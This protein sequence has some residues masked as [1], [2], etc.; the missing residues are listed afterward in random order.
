MRASPLPRRL[1]RLRHLLRRNRR[2][3]SRRNIVAHYDLGDDFYRLRLDARMQCSSALWADDTPTSPE[4]AGKARLPRCFD[5]LASDLNPGGRPW[6][7]GRVASRSIAKVAL[8]AT[9][10]SLTA[11][12]GNWRS[13][14]FRR[15]PGRKEQLSRPAA[16]AGI[17]SPDPSAETARRRTPCRSPGEPRQHEAVEPDDGNR[18]AVTGFSPLLRL[19]R[20]RGLGATPPDRDAPARRGA[21]TAPQL[22]QAARPAGGMGSLT[23]LTVQSAPFSRR[24]PSRRRESARCA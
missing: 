21:V 8:R 14:R 16:R 22:E 20:T 18:V 24:D 6:P 13:T 17:H 10:G 5:T 4:A 3:G 2:G 15:S 23:A 1:E 7:T 19:R 12:R 9:N 11:A